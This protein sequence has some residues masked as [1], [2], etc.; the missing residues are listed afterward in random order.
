MKTT[1]WFSPKNKPVRN[2]VYQIYW[3]Y[4]ENVYA[5][6][7]GVAWSRALFSI[8]L[9]YRYKCEY[10][11]FQNKTWRGLTRESK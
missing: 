10:S 9:A 7:D 4:A 6:W 3:Q 8:E 11:Q 5:F 2:G 1:K